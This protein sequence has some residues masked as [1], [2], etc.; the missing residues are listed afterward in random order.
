MRTATFLLCL[1]GCGPAT[2]P[3]VGRDASARDSAADA[4][5]EDAGTSDGGID[6]GAN[7]DAGRR[8]TVEVSHPREVRGTW[9]ATVSRIN[10]PKT[11][12]PARQRAD[13]EAIFDDAVAAGLNTIFFQVRPEAD[14]LYDSEL[15]PW[16][17]FL[18]GTQG[19]DPGYDPLAFAIDQAHARGLELHAWLN[20]YRARAGSGATSPE[21]VSRTMPEAVVTYGSQ[22]WLDPG[23]PG[24]FEHTLAVVRDIVRRYDVD[25]VHMD[26]YFYP[27]PADGAH[28]DD[29]ATYAAYG[30]GLSRADWRRENVNRMV[31]RVGEVVAEEDP[32]V[33]WGISPFGIYRPGMPEGVVGLDQYGVLYADV[34]AWMR[35]GWLDYVA[36]QLYWPTTSSGQPFGTLLDWWADRATETGRTLLVGSSASRRYGLSEYTRQLDLVA[37]ARDRRTYGMVWWSVAPIV[38]NEDGLRDMLAERY[39]RPAASPPLVGAT[40]TPQAPLVRLADDGAIAVRST[41]DGLRYWA[42]YTEAAGVWQLQR[43]FPASRS[44]L[45]LPGGR[46]AISAIARNGLESEGVVIETSGVEPPPPP[47]AGRSCTHSFGGIYIDRGCSPSY[48]CCDG[49]WRPRGSCGGC[50]CEEDTGMVGCSR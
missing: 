42:A 28:F 16:S 26:D 7:R 39:A 4:A 22:L 25:G 31:R 45:A 9:V 36:P 11:D 17:R 33:R 19:L 24:A 48:Q 37:E 30:A 29:D 15:E 13:L 3:S 23:H 21:H 46:W 2:P 47:P 27:Y 12:D 14:A 6:S 1:V 40:A 41:G 43:L 50:A 32:D 20:P 44:R 5:R 8:E 10:W 49:T 38:A 34:L 18:T 35:G